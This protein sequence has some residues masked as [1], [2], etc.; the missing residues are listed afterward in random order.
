MSE[1]GD[2]MSGYADGDRVEYV[3]N[4]VEVK[5]AF[6]TIRGAG[7]AEGRYIV[8][9][10]YGDVLD[11]CGSVLQAAEIEGE[12]EPMARKTVVTHPDGTQSTRNSANNIY[13]YA[14]ERREDMWATAKLR[15]A[16]AAETRAAKAKFIEAVRGG[17][18]VR[19][20]DAMAGYPNRANLYVAHA[21]GERF[22]LG[23][24]HGYGDVGPMDRKAA[25]REVL[26]RYERDA[27]RVEAEAREAESGPQY[28]YGVVRWSMS[29]DNAGKGAAEFRSRSFPTSTFRVVPAEAAE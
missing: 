1:G 17:K 11:M 13:T 22:W 3:G 18:V 21:D 8:E 12:A 16:A 25:V 5:G 7:Y 24:E 23:T 27:G 15:H 19:E 29:H 2:G 20:A 9:F 28:R 14:V 6:G 10:D 26:E 4:V